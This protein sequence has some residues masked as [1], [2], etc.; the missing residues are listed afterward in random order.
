[1]AKR[2]TADDLI[3]AKKAPALPEVPKDLLIELEKVIN[4]N[5]ACAANGAKISRPA[6]HEM[7]EQYGLIGLSTRTLDRIAQAHFG[8]KSFGNK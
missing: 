2:I 5:D 3:Q 7:C 4:Y 6:V 8:R 1:M